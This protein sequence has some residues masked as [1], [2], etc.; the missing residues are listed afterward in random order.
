MRTQ[1]KRQIK[2]WIIIGCIAGLGSLA[3]TAAADTQVE[4]MDYEDGIT[5]GWL[6]NGQTKFLGRATPA[7]PAVSR[8]PTSGASP[9]ATKRR[10][11]PSWVMSPVTPATSA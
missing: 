4:V 3:T 7:T 6:V 10:P 9:S 8:S 2:N 11:A 1:V 5:N